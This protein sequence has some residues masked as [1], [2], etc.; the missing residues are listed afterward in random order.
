MID[1]SRLSLYSKKILAAGNDFNYLL[2]T[3]A[4]LAAFSGAFIGN[5]LVK[6]VTIRSLQLFVAVLLFIF[7]ILLG[8]GII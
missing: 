6:K 5:K 3:C 8:M 2:I 1:V 4:A 7:S